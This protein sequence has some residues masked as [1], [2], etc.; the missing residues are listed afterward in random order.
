MYKIAVGNE[1]YVQLSI[2]DQQP[3]E[4]GLHDVE[5][6]SLRMTPKFAYELSDRLKEYADNAK[7]V[8]W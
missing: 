7:E 8:K 5:L 2:M 1:G 4:E 6:A 3:D